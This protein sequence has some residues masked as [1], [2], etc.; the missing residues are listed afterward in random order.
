M[1]NK[2]VGSDDGALCE[3]AWLVVRG[4]KIGITITHKI[5]QQLP[6]GP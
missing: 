4:P 5:T 1:K 6:N 2:A 3:I